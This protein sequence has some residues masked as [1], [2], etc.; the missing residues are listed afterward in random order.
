M[1]FIELSA[2]LKRDLLM[3]AEETILYGVETG[4]YL[5]LTHRTYDAELRRNRASFVTLYWH[6][7][8]RGCIGSVRPARPLLEDV[9]HNAYAAAFRDSRFDPLTAAEFDDLQIEISVLSPLQ[10]MRF[11]DERD[12]IEQLQPNVD[13]VIIQAGDYRA[14]FLPKVWE[15]LPRKREF[16]SQLKLKAGLTPD[17]WSDG[18]SCYRY[19]TDTFSTEADFG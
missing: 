5:S 12:L 13:G 1:P 11:E 16:F 9:A 3:V 10:P 17:F 8:L 6:Q 15:S 4:R 14:T 18:I 7:Q 19:T 2:K